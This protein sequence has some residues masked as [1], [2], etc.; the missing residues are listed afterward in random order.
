MSNLLQLPMSIENRRR[1]VYT[2]LSTFL[3]GDRL[4]EAVTLWEDVYSASPAFS[5]QKFLGEV[6]DTP[7][8]KAQRVRML[9]N[10]LKLLSAPPAT[11]LPDP[12]EQLLVWR[13]HRGR[14]VSAAARSSDPS[15]TA[16]ASLLLR[17]L[18]GLNGDNRLR[19]RLFLLAQ[20]ERSNLPRET[21]NAIQSWLNEQ[22]RVTLDQANDGDMQRLLNLAYIGLCEYIG[23]VAADAALSN[24]MQG[25]ARD[26]PE[27][28][29]HARALL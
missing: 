27:L 16:C 28:L 4:W 3:E 1:A 18:Q 9:Q 13:S 14:N 29:P 22:N 21:R 17:I 10:M 5:V 24:A 7:E 8:L 19:M 6:L 25:I 12:R 15:V 2:A 26:E 11:L 23:P 20:L